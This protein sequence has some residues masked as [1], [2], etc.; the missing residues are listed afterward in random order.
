MDKHNHD[1][2]HHDSPEDS[3]DHETHDHDGHD[4]SSHDHETHDHDGHDHSSHDHGS[5]DHGDAAA[6]RLIFAIGLLVLT[7][8][9]EI[10]G[11]LLTG[12]LALLADAGHVFM[13]LFA[14][15]LSLIAARLARRAPSTTQTYGLHRAEILA[16][17][18]NGSLLVVLSLLLFREA[19]ERFHAPTDILAIPMLIVAVVG[20]IV[21]I[22]IAFRLHGHHEGDLNMTS[23]YLHVLGDAGAS[24]G[25]VVAAIVIHFT[26]WTMVDSLISAAIGILILIGALRLLFNAGHV[27][28]ESVPR[29]LSLEAVE[30]AI[31]KHDGVNSVH[32]LHIWTLCSHIINLSC[33]INI[34]TR[35]PQHHDRVVT[36]LSE[37]LWR[38]FC[39]MHS[40]IQVD[41]ENCSDQ[42]VMQDM[43]HPSAHG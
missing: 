37:M 30:K 6:G 4:H 11:G 10:I 20:L 17:L 33:H 43:A 41:Y 8:A 19:W 23:A 40:T 24:A 13:D 3:H 7:L 18:M 16:A 27:L 12:S 35:S 39:I 15:S 31:A 2:H 36:S 21:N 5:H 25:V 22:V 26:G 29:G 14:L 28:L 42:I 38:R 9:A 32:D 1:D 34:E